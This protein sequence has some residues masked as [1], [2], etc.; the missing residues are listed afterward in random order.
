M[1]SFI[2]VGN[3]SVQHSKTAVGSS[4]PYGAWF[5]CAMNTVERPT[6]INGSDTK[7]ALR[8]ALNTLT[9]IPGRYPDR[10]FTF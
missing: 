9:F 5:V 6:Q 2:E 10:I 7:R 4:F 3:I 1:N 8:S